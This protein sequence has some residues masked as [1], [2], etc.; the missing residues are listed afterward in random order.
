[1]VSHLTEHKRGQLFLV[2]VTGSLGC[3]KSRVSH[4][5]AEQG[6][7]LLDADQDARAVLEPGSAGWQE[8]VNH[9]G[10]TVLHNSSHPAAIDRRRLGEIVFADPMACTA[11]EAIVHPR[12]YRRQ[13]EQLQEWQRCTPVGQTSVVIAEVPLLFE[14]AVAHR[15]DRTVVVLC[16][17][18]QMQRLRERSNMSATVQQAIIARQ[19]SEHEK[20]QRAWYCID[21]QGEWQNTQRQLHALWSTIQQELTTHQQGAWPA[22]WPELQNSVG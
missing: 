16:G 1:M 12:I 17:A 20:Q 14:A 3:G 10:S 7:F 9:F 4:W 6:A 5:L 21:N 19:L 15:F 18:Q 2:A 11:L 8:V 22:R 13:A